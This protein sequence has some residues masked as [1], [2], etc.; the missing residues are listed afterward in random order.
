MSE[1]I[2]KEIFSRNL[3]KI[4]AKSDKSQKEIADSIGV[5]PQTF[6]TWYKGIALPRMG[7]VQLLADYFGISKSTL[8]ENHSDE[9]ESHYYI[10]E[11]ARDMAQFLF[12]NP[13]Y[14]V[15][16]SAVKNVSK[17]DLETVKKIIDKFKGEDN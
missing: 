13:D 9:S 2:Q 12:E 3:Q 11:D 1:E 10:N 17:E 14:K 8:L 15:L 7:K 6:N 4:L 16:F 5:S